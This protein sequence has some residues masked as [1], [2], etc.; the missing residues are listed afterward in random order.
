MVTF[1]FASFP[2]ILLRIQEDIRSDCMVLTNPPRQSWLREVRSTLM[3]RAL[4][5]RA[6]EPFEVK[7]MNTVVQVCAG[8]SSMLPRDAFR[9]DL[10]TRTFAGSAA[11]RQMPS[12]VSFLS[13]LPPLRRVFLGWGWGGGGLPISID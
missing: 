5:G 13:E 9:N 3:W 2:S 7:R 8:N 4:T 6:G 10:L 11:S 12:A 1:R